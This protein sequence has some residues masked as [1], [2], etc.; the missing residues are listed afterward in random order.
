MKAFLAIAV[1]LLAAS[2]PLS[3][4]AQSADAG[5]ADTEQVFRFVE[6]MPEFDGNLW[7]YMHDSL[8]YPDSARE[9]GAQGKVVL[10]FIVT[11]QGTLR[12]IEVVRSAGNA[13]L[14]SEAVRL[15]RAM[16][17]WRPG[18]QNGKVVNVIYTLP[19]TFQ[20]D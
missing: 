10:N 14:D 4:R 15:V 19:L 16:P 9:A 13:Q 5:T 12:D 1:L 8:S 20:L 2:F 18:K 6:Q 17:P 7:R 3:L 11:R